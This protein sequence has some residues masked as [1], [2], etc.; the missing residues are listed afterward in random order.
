MTRRLWLLLAM[1]A[2]CSA[3]GVSLF[4]GWRWYAAPPPPE[5]PDVNLA[6]AEPLVAHVIQKA[7]A[8]VRDKPYSAET[9]GRLSLVLRAHGYVDEAYVCFI[10]AERFDPNDPRWPYFQGH[11]LRFSQP[12]AALC[13]VERAVAL[14]DEHAPDKVA[15]RLVLA[16]MLLD[17]GRIAEAETQ[18]QKVLQR[19]PS[20]QRAAYDLGLAAFARDDTTECLR[21]LTPLAESPAARK[22]VATQLAMV[23][24]RQEDADKAAEFNRKARDLPAD[25]AWFDPYLAEYKALDVGHYGRL[26]KVDE[27]GQDEGSLPERLRLL[28][29]LIEDFPED[30]YVRLALGITLLNAG[31]YDAAERVARDTGLQ[32]PDK[33]QAQYFL[34]VV[35]FRQAETLRGDKARAK[36]RQALE[37]AERALEFKSDHGQARLMRGKSLRQLGERA[38]ALAELR[39]AVLDRPDLAE[40]HLVLGQTL[41]DAGLDGEALAELQTAMTMAQKE[42]KMAETARA[43]YVQVVLRTFLP[44]FP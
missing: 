24:L 21:Y 22:K 13:R 23:Y 44:L 28:N 7:L 2:L 38:E 37:A 32:G 12:D 5:P 16:E 39:R 26:M 27:M 29:Q 11:Y 15:P 36:Y 31:D 18:L 9:W 34:S 6:G 10:Q 20:N 3:L 1:L 41:A 30:H 40:T 43:R 25:Q 42:P 17:K 19:D 33:M 14:C 8:A 35:L 4:Y